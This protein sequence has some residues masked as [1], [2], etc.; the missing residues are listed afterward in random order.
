VHLEFTLLVAASECL[1]PPGHLLIKS[2]YEVIMARTSTSQRLTKSELKREEAIMVEKGEDTE[3]TVA[4][5]Q[6][7]S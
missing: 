3:S 6:A 5:E 4:T 7:P 1:P 2:A